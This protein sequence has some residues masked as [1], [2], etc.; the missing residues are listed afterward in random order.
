MMIFV[1]GK[2]SSFIFALL[3]GDKVESE[4]KFIRRGGSDSNRDGKQRYFEINC[5]RGGI[6]RHVRL[7]I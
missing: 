1:E 6:G 5:G 7:R 4:R 2:K 3:F